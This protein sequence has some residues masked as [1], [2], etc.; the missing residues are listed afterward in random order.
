MAKK[1]KCFVCGKDITHNINYNREIT[2]FN[3]NLEQS[4]LET[5]IKKYRSAD[6]LKELAKELCESFNKFGF[7][8]N[9]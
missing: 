3:S 1:K 4:E 9:Y 2:L 6:S 7:S 5:L 8:S